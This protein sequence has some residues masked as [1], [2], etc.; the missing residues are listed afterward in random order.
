VRDTDQKPCG[1]TDRTPA[2]YINGKQTM[3]KNGRLSYTA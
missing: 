2:L 1:A 3:P